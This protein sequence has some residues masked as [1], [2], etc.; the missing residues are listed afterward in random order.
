MTI[1]L[2]CFPKYS[3]VSK[4]PSVSTMKSS[5]APNIKQGLL[6][7]SSRIKLALPSVVFEDGSFLDK[8]ILKSL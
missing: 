5:R 2:L 7:E 1:S 6:K 3:A 8:S 4:S